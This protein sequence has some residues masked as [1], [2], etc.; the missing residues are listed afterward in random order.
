[1]KKVL[2]LLT[3]ALMLVAVGCKKDKSSSSS[4]SSTVKKYF[5]VQGADYKAT[6]LPSSTSEEEPLVEMGGQ[7][8]IPGGT[9][10]VTVTYP[11][12][13]SKILIG[14]EGKSGHY[15][16]DADQRLSKEYSYDFIMVVNQTLTD[17]SF[18]IIVGILDADGEVSQYIEFPM[19][20]HVVGTGELQ[21][22][23]SFDNDKDIDLHLF[24]PNGYHI[25]YGNS[26]S[27]NGGELDLDSNA[28]CNI[29]GINNENIT[30]GDGAYVEPGDYIV[31]VDMW[32]NCDPSIATNFVVTVLYEGEILETIEG[33]NPIAGT[34]PVNE[35]SNYADL[36]NIQP[37][38]HFTIPDNGQA[39]SG[40]TIKHGPKFLRSL[41]KMQ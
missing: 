24:E 21:V 29:D 15:E 36:D 16:V 26:M 20:L 25:Y 38:C 2:L 35:P 23:L 11:V 7:T 1:M 34:F 28:G 41:D 33:I 14:V 22:S 3:A 31:Y 30:Y 6:A 18:T 4:N 32:E 12:E 8:V 27:D 9:K 19:A 17:D 40:K 10:Y 13:A 37:V 5:E 39:K